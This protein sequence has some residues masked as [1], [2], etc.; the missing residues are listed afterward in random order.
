LRETEV[1]FFL[2]WFVLTL[3]AQTYFV[4][5]WNAARKRKL[6]PWFVIF[7]GGLFVAPIFIAA[8]NMAV[9]IL[10]G[11]GMSGLTAIQIYRVWF[12]DHCGATVGLFERGITRQKQCNKC[13]ADL[14][15]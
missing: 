2:P 4:F 14:K 6:W 8:P 1:I 12:C 5:S 10:V 3:A 11:V 9:L 13:G 7:S 15:A